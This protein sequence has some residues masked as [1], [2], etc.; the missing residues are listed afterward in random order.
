MKKYRIALAEEQRQLLQQ[1]IAAGQAPARTLTHARVLLKADEGEQGPGW[2]DEQISEALEV[3]PATIQRVRQRF[4]EAG[5]EDA[6]KRRPQPERPEKRKLAGVQEAH[7]IAL[8]CGPAPQGY[9]RWSMRLLAD[10]FVVVETGEHVGR[11]TIRRAL[12][13]MN[14]SPG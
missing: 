14:S 10:R 9:Q 13:K 3:S 4:I 1:M 11:E 8:S 5:L 6:L 7:L 12:K 2:T